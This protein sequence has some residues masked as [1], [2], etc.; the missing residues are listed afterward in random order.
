M[1]DLESLDAE[2]GLR[3]LLA[4]RAIRVER[5]PDDEVYRFTAR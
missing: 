4:A 3:E 5:T 2:P 1:T